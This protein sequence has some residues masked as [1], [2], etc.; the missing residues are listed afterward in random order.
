M[1]DYATATQGILGYYARKIPLTADSSQSEIVEGALSFFDNIPGGFI[2]GTDELLN[3]LFQQLNDNAG[4]QGWA[5]LDM[6]ELLEQ[7]QFET[8]RQT[9]CLC[10]NMS[11]I[12]GVEAYVDYRYPDYL[13]E[14]EVKDLFREGDYPSSYW[15][16]KLPTSVQYRYESSGEWEA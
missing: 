15:V 11:G 2:P 5:D 6:L 4:P 1:L 10:C 8:P 9:W 12:P 16:E 7:Q 3:M 14:K 13:S